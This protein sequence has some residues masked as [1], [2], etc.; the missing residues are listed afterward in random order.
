MLCPLSYWGTC[1]GGSIEAWG[2]NL[3]WD[4]TRSES[5]E[6]LDLVSLLG[7]LPLGGVDLVEVAPDFDPSER[8][9]ALATGLLYKILGSRVFD[10][11]PFA[12]FANQ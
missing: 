5:S 8:T 4:R 10:F 2:E 7:D 12:P 9:P 1:S 3:A 6:M 11:A